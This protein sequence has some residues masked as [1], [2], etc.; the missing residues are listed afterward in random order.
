MDFIAGGGALIYVNGVGARVSKGYR[1][2]LYDKPSLEPRPDFGCHDSSIT[3]PQALAVDSVID[4]YNYA[5]EQAVRIARREGQDW[6]LLDVAG[7]LADLASPRY[8]N[9]PLA[10]SEG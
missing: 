5:I 9:D 4:Q 3:A 10:R 7:I 2:F 8:I 1:Y 6:Y